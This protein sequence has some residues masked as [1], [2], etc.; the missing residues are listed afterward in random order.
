[1]SRTRSKPE[2][3]APLALAPERAKARYEKTASRAQQQPM[4]AIKLKCLGCC[5]WE[6]A[7]AKQCQ[8]STC[9]LWA[10]NRRIFAR[11]AGAESS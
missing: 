3:Y 10:L 8:I 9:A 7:E 11:G 5:A 1:M 6:Y 2:G 4:A